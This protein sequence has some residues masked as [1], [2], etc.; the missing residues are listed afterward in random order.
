MST[1]NTKRNSTF[2]LPTTRKR[3]YTHG[4]FWGILAFF[5]GVGITLVTLPEQFTQSDIE[6][7]RI[8]T[9]IWLNA[10]GVGIDGAQVG[11]WDM[12]FQTVTFIESNPELHMLRIVP[13]LLAALA[14]LLVTASMGGARRDKHIL[15]N[16]VTASGGYVLASLGAIVVSGARPGVELIIL[17]TITLAGGI[18]LG[19]LL[20][21]QLPIPV[22]AVTTLGGLLGI[23]LFVFLAAGVVS[24]VAIPLGKHAVSGG[25]LAS[26]LLWVANNID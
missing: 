23:G 12:A 18:Y 13:V 5:G 4:I 6:Q 8:A 11:G 15:E 2:S 21:N 9:W 22:F 16:C 17:L 10:H 7:W 1:W 3:Q 19:A 14:G 26:M 24:T 20:A 25:I